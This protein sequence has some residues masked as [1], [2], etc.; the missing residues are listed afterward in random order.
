M[1]RRRGFSRQFLPGWQRIDEFI[2][3]RSV[4]APVW[5]GQPW[6]VRRVDN[7]GW[8]RCKRTSRGICTGLRS[9][10]WAWIYRLWTTWIRHL[11]DLGRCIRQLLDG[12]GLSEVAYR[13]RSCNGVGRREGFSSFSDGHLKFLREVSTIFSG[14]CRGILIVVE[15]ELRGRAW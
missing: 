11:T 3:R 8:R 4:R 13:T 2:V 12:R 5:C 15:G 14:W 1:H 10:A 7:V 9:R 6:R